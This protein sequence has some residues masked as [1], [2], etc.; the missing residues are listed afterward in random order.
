MVLVSETMGEVS[1]LR[2]GTGRILEPEKHPAHFVDRTPT[3]E[4]TMKRQVPLNV[5]RKTHC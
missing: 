2:A 4:E 3:Q 5:V 1:V